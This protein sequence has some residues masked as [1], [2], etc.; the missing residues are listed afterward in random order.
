MSEDA[1]SSCSPY[2]L[3]E[4]REL[5]MACRQISESRGEAAPP[6]AACT[7]K[8]ICQQQSTGELIQLPRA[9]SAPHDGTGAARAA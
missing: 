5:A 7:L 8:A 3:K 6:C 1:K 9:R 2:L 4:R